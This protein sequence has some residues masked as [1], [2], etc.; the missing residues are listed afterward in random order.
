MMQIGLGAEQ[1]AA[2]LGASA[3]WGGV[4]LIVVYSVLVAVVLPTPSELILLVPLL[5]GAPPEVR[6]TVIILLGATGK[7][8]GSVLAVAFSRWVPGLMQSPTPGWVRTAAMQRFASLVDRYGPAG[9][10]LALCVPGVPDTLPIYGFALLGGS[11]RAYAAA[12]FIGGAGRYVVVLL[13]VGGALT[14]I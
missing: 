3:G 5:P 12:T 8:A 9:L 2:V 4:V 6:W 10:A 13:G 1:W 14:I 11:Y 7:M